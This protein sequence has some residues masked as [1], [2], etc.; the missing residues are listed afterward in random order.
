MKTPFE[1]AKIRQN[2][3]Q[4]FIFKIKLCLIFKCNN[5][6]LLKYIAAVNLESNFRKI[7][8]GQSVLIKANSAKFSK[9]FFKTFIPN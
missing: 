5:F 3:I 9:D 4:K 8:K 7:L 6:F 1:S 2:C